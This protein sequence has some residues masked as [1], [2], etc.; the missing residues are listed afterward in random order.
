MGA[1]GHR[2]CMPCFGIWQDE[3]PKHS[4]VAS[5]AAPEDI[6]FRKAV[7]FGEG[8][9]VLLVPGV[10]ERALTD[11]TASWVGERRRELERQATRARREEGAA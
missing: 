1:W 9:H 5:S 4:G 8:E 11:F 6:A 3:S 10:F 2:L 7:T